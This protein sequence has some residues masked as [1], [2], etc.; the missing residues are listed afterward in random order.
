MSEDFTELDPIQELPL[1]QLL[2]KPVHS[3]SDQELSQ[4]RAELALLRRPQTLTAKINSE[5]T[6]SVKKSAVAKASVLAN[7]YL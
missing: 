5:A 2:T 7:K 6:R 1:E 4:Y 3:M